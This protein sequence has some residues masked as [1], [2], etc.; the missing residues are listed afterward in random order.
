MSE[1]EEL[2][3]EE[4]Y[5]EPHWDLLHEQLRRAFK[6]IYDGDGEK[7]NGNDF[8]VLQALCLCQAMI[9]PKSYD[10]EELAKDFIWH[11]YHT[12]EFIHLAAGDA[13]NKKL[14]EAAKILWS[15]KETIEE[16]P[17]I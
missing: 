6:W 1:Q 5:P 12:A 3:E 11:V 10:P 17:T 13:G 16:S 9:L 14:F 2:N 8:I 4:T 15:L 7:Y